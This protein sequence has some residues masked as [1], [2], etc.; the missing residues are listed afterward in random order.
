MEQLDSM[1]LY[2]YISY[3][4]I[5]TYRQS[6]T[7]TDRHTYIF[8]VEEILTYPHYLTYIYTSHRAASSS[9]YS[10]YPHKVWYLLFTSSYFNKLD[11]ITMSGPPPPPRNKHRNSTHKQSRHQ[12]QEEYDN[13][14]DQQSA[15]TGAGYNVYNHSYVLYM[16]AD[17]FYRQCDRE[18]L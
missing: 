1:E 14:R 15:V 7:H 6:Y 10:L 2:V 3:S 5:H 9:S 8:N 13:Y 12:S 11:D 17:S 18:M 4:Y 16:L